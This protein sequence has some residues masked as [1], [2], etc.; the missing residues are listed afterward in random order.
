M[1]QIE[2]DELPAQARLILPT[3]ESLFQFPNIWDYL[4]Y[5]GNW[6]VFFFL[7]VVI[8]TIVS[9]EVQ[10]KTQRQTIING[11]ERN[12]YFTSKM[13]VVLAFT[14][15]ATLYYCA[16]AMGVGMFMTEDWDVAY[17]L[18]NN[19]AILRYFLMSLGYLSFAAFIAF[20]VKKPGLASFLYLSYAIMI[21]P[22]IKAIMKF[23][24]FLPPEAGNYLP[25][26]A[27]E[28]L[29]PFP[30]YRITEYLPKNTDFAFLLPDFHAILV[31]VGYT[32]VF[33]GLTFFIFKRRDL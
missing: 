7:G 27:M 3:S 2:L 4:G 14:I 11:M 10:Y 16:I 23:K 8:I 30:L 19:K 21:E 18:D 9:A 6:M 26:N 13:Y 12:T 29:M 5:V 28:D 15:I 20:M 33:V 22:I 17:M 31:S 25:L 1:K 32:L 24:D